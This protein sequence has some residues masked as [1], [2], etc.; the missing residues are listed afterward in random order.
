MK[1]IKFN[2]TSPECARGEIMAT[3]DMKLEKLRS[4]LLSKLLQLSQDI[5]IYKE[6]FVYSCICQR[7]WMHLIRY[8]SMMFL[9]N[10]WVWRITLESSTG[11]VCQIVN[12]IRAWIEH[13]G[14]LV[15]VRQ[16]IITDRQCASTLSDLL[17]SRPYD[18][19]FPFH[20]SKYIRK[21]LWFNGLGTQFQCGP[22]D[23]FGGSPWF[24][25]FH[26]HASSHEQT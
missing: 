9:H 24:T 2:N 5:Y 25:S 12:C 1:L 16:F 22:L 23:P 3:H 6:K 4:I 15:V 10:I 13:Q 18:T 19:I 21:V 26:S 11:G 17:F 20:R 7:R 8:T 14:L